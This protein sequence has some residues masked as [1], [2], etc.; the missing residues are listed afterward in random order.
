MSNDPQNATS[1]KDFVYKATDLQDHEAIEFV[2]I[3]HAIQ[4]RYAGKANTEKNLDQMR[5]EILT[6]LAEKLGILASFD[7]TPCFYGEPPIVEYLGK[8]SGDNLHKYGFD[9]EQ[10]EYEVKEAVKRGEEFRGQKER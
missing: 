4:G 7:P 10:K 2:R 9:H 5:D 1:P 3:V 6:Q 8:V